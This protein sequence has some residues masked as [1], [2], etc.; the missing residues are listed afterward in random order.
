MINADMAHG[1]GS[2]CEKVTAV[3][4]AAIVAVSD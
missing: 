2:R 1:G 3:A 4:V